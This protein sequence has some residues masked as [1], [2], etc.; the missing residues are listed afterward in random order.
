M[1]IQGL[2][3]DIHSKNMFTLLLQ[4]REEDAGRYVCVASNNVGSDEKVT[5]IIINTAP[6]IKGSNGDGEYTTPTVHRENLGET[7]TLL[8]S[9]LSFT[10]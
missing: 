9:H 8:V 7:F 4:S 6:T 1:L 3:S 10:I 2:L 5:E